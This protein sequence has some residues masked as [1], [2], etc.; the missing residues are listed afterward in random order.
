MALGNDEEKVRLL[1]ADAERGEA[2]AQRHLANRYLRGK[3]LPAD[4]SLAA[5][6]MERAARQGLAPAQ[7]SF[8][9]FLEQG[10]GLDPD[11]EGARTWYAAASE[12]G[13]PVAR[14]HLQRLEQS[15]P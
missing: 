10:V 5:F 12:Q 11:P 6:W 1:Q 7:R 14:R 13:D 2:R 3:G 4:P 9:E 15:D 8:G